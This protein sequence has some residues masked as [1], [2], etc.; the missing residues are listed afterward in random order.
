MSDQ[1][2]FC[3]LSHFVP[4]TS[5][6]LVVR[7][8]FP[9]TEGHTL[10]V[11]RQHIASLFELTVDE[12]AELWQLVAQV[13]SSLVEQFHPDAFNIGINDGEAA[14]Q[15]IPHAHIHVVPRYRGDVA[16]PRG[17]VRW[18]IPQK[19]AYWEVRS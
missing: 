16:D 12:Q 18:V 13:R 1:C 3:S 2:P 5:V 11:P 17:G 7:D 14:G 6:G 10:I 4:S 9:L 15:T 19:A 8:A